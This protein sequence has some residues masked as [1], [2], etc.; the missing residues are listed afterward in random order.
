MPR[1]RERPTED[2]M[3]RDVRRKAL[4]GIRRLSPQEPLP[5]ASDE[6][7]PGIRLQDIGVQLAKARRPKRKRRSE[8]A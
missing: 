6:I 1:P 5:Q 4:E 7:T 2:D 3:L 8:V